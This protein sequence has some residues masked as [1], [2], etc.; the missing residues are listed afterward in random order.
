[1]LIPIKINNKSSQSRAGNQQD[2]RYANYLQTQ[3]CGD[4]I[5]YTREFRPPGVNSL[6]TQTL[7]ENSELSAPVLQMERQGIES[8][9]IRFQPA[10]ALSRVR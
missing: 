3:V 10:W 7:F 5:N 4:Q 9:W 6:I 2:F 8:E 1:M